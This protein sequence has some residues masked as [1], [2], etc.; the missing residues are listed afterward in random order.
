VDSLRG[1]LNNFRSC[2]DVYFYNLDIDI[3]I[4]SKSIAG[5]VDIYFSVVNDFDTMQIDLYPNMSLD[6][7]VFE[8]KNLHF[9][10]VYGAVFVLFEKHLT[11][12]EKAKIRVYYHGKPVIAKKPPWE[13][14]FVWKKDKNKNPWIGVAC[15]V[16]GA[17]LWWPV[18]DHLSDKPD[19]MKLNFTVP[20]GLMCVS[21]GHMVD[22]V[23]LMNKTKYTWKLTY[24]VNSYNAT[25]YIGKF[26]HFSMPYQGADTSFNLDFYVIPQH[27]EKA[28][29]HF[30]QVQ[31]ILHFYESAFGPYP[32]PKDGYK[33][34]E[35]P[36]EGMENQTAIAYGNN[37]NNFINAFDQII[38]H[39]TAHEWW[40]NS[41]NVPDYAEVW[42]HE[43]M[44]TYAEAMYTEHNYGH[45]FYLSYL[46]FYALLIR[47]KKTVVVLMM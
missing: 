43:G 13:G 28:K 20:A 34:V 46:K 22:S 30:L 17:S 41:I 12:N 19:S 42:I 39:E 9:N 1:K 25:L 31:S 4:N 47:N 33:L 36:Y 2:Y 38:L 37:Y 40:G 11:T 23:P 14:G 8:K 45:N 27:L 44:A 26:S 21:N 7:I 6:S 29:E 16:A 24:P 35:S 5:F 18:K 3:N 32:W 10:R 15:E